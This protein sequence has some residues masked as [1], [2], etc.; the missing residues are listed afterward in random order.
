MMGLQHAVLIEYFLVPRF[1]GIMYH[2]SGQ[3]K[4]TACLSVMQ[5]IWS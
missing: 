1:L 4:G 5:A 3:F 2:F